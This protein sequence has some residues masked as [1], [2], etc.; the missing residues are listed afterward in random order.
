M[1]AA[2]A[3]KLASFG[4]GIVEAT[5]TDWRFVPFLASRVLV[6]VVDLT[7]TALLIWLTARRRKN[8]AR[9]CL[10]ALLCPALFLLSNLV[11]PQFRY[12]LRAAGNVNSVALATWLLQAIALYFAFT[13]DAR[14]IFASKDVTLRSDQRRTSRAIGLIWLVILSV[15]AA[16]S[17]ISYPMFI[18]LG[19][20]MCDLKCNFLTPLAFISLP[21]ALT[22]GAI[23]GWSRRSRDKTGKLIAWSLIPVAT[24]VCLFFVGG[25]L[26]DV[27]P[28]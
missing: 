20:T 21:F 8:W 16:S 19:T 9:W 18:F 25:A 10:V 23:V 22:V 17:L 14:P 4:Y 15:A 7:V 11:F 24:D 27:L 13:G 26:R 1:Y 2:L 3:I 5:K 6:A 28:L 12:L